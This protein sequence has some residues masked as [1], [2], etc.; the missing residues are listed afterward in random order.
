MNFGTKM[1]IVYKKEPR[2]KAFLG[3][4]LGTSAVKALLMAEE[5]QILGMGSSDLSF[6]VSKPAF[7]EQ[8]PN[9][10]W[11]GAITAVGQAIAACGK[12]P[13]VAGIGVS[14]QMLGSVLMDRD[15]NA[16]ESC[17]IWMDQRAAKERDYVENKL[18]L[19]FILDKTANYP[20]VSLWAPKLLW[21][22][23]N[24]PVRYGQ[25]HK[26]LF[27]KDYLKYRLTGVYD[28]DVTEAPG[29]LLFNTIK[30]NWDD[31]LFDAFDIP[32]GFVPESLSESVDVI[33]C[34]SKIAADALGIPKGIPVVGGGGDQMCGAVGLGVV[35]RGIV[36]S[37]I[38]TSGC[39]F[40][41]SDSCIIDRKPRALL[42]YCHSV[43]G[44]YSV[45]GCTLSAGGAYQ[46]LRNT[47]FKN[48]HVQWNTKGKGI[49]AFM[50]SLAAGVD[51]GCEGLVFLPYIN[52]ER[53]PHPDPNA[54][55]V[56]FGLSH[57]HGAGALCRAVM[58]GVVFSLRD[59]V[60]IIREHR[61]PVDQIRAAGGGA[62]SPLWL[63]MQADIFGVPV[64]VTNIQEA[65]AAGAAMLAAT[66]TGVYSR[67]NE[68]AEKIIRITGKYEP[69][70][71]N[72]A[73]YTDYY[74]TYRSL[75]PALSSQY[76]EQVKKVER[77][78][79]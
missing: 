8:N 59:T 63:Q 31:D 78:G 24:D 19:D 66:G 44:A 20:L 51:P 40:S 62:V 57:R 34:V 13:E 74:E 45:F 2:M 54:R 53:T 32:R 36:S 16:D 15:G 50:D 71:K 18:G 1:I 72:T 41:H 4:D 35:S 75:Y 3:I 39:V 27:P 56:F 43:P 64:W 46:W 69:D 48:Q 79:N 58:E 70:T 7:A 47:F 6:T 10:W 38:G 17:I 5:G 49:Y 73:K 22:R 11:N 29:T 12:K 55:G 42:S 33:G 52:G 67:L 37:A 23:K 21:L 77:W 26:V 28:I 68:A 65:P 25:I 60:E 61:I 14:G 30:R 9:D 76:A